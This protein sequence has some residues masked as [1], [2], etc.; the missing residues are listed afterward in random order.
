MT[1]IEEIEDLLKKWEESEEW[2]RV[3]GIKQS[4]GE[5]RG[6]KAA[7]RILNENIKQC[8]YCGRDYEY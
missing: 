5:V 7:L 8:I 1:K 4:S 3:N 6:L 2:D